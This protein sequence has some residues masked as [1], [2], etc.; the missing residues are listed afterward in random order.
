MFV[1]NKGQY[2]KN[3]VSFETLFPVNLSCGR[4]ADVCYKQ[5]AGCKRFRVDFQGL[6]AAHS[7]NWILTG[8]RLSS[9]PLT[10]RVIQGDLPL[11]LTNTKSP[12]APLF[13]GGSPIGF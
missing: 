4:I 6:L 11:I 9:P 7:S 10:I 13:K 12:L 8:V 2:A 5:R 3:F 1:T